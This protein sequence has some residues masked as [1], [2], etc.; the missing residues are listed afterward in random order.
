MTSLS[1]NGKS[2]DSLEDEIKA[3]D[4]D[5]SGFLKTHK[6]GKTFCIL[7]DVV[8]VSFEAFLFLVTKT[9]LRLGPWFKSFHDNNPALWK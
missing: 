3:G 4:G 2:A 6:R 9:N 1:T 8:V 5:N 7:N